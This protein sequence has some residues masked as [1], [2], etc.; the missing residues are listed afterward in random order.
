M[1][2][3]LLE[4]DGAL[5]HEEACESLDAKLGEEALV[6]AMSGQEQ[7]SKILSALSPISNKRERKKNPRFSDYEM[8]EKPENPCPKQKRGGRP[9]RKTS[10]DTETPQPT[11]HCGSKAAEPTDQSPEQQSPQKK[12][13][14]RPPKDKS[15]SQQRNDWDKKAIAPSD[16]GDQ[17]TGSHTS[18]KELSLKSPDI[19]AK[20]KQKTPARKKPDR[21]IK[22]E[23]LSTEAE[24]AFSEQQPVETPK[25]KRKYLKKK[26]VPPQEMAPMLQNDTEET[27]AR[28]DP[29]TNLGGRPRRSAAKTALKYLH[30]LAQESLS[31][32]EASDSRS[33]SPDSLSDRPGPRQGAAAMRC[34][35]R[36]P[37]DCD[38]FEGDE[39]FLPGGGDEEMLDDMED[40]EDEEETEGLES[41]LEP[42]TQYLNKSNILHRRVFGVA[43][44]GIS[45]AMMKPALDAYK[46]NKKFR[47]EHHSDSVFP[48]W[49]PTVNDWTLVSSSELEKYLPR[50]LQ[51]AAFKVSR[52]GLGNKETVQRLN[53]FQVSDPHPERLDLTVFVGGPVWALEWCPLPDGATAHQYLALACHQGMDQQHVFNQMYAGAG[54][55]QLWDM[56]GLD[57]RSRPEAGPASLVYGLGQEKGFVWQLKWCPAGAWE[58]PN[59]SRKA[60]FLQRL[61]LLAVAV[62]T[63]VVSIYSLPHPQALCSPWSSEGDN[64]VPPVYQAREVLTL[65]L[66]ASKA[67]HHDKSGQ[68]LS[69]DWLPEK[70]HNIMAIGFYDGTVGLWDLSSCSSLL[71]VCDPSNGLTL[72]P[73]RC[74]VAHDNAVR[75]LCFCPASSQVMATGGNDRMVKLWDLKRLY[76]PINVQKRNLTTEV[77]WPLAS[78][79]TFHSQE[80]SYASRG[81]TGA[82]YNDLGYRNARSVFITPRTGTVWSLS[83]SDWCN[84]LVTGDGLGE[85]IFAL[86]PDFNCTNPSLRRTVERRFPIYFTDMV[87]YDAEEERGGKGGRGKGEMSPGRL[88]NNNHSEE[89]SASSDEE[90]RSPEERPAEGPSTQTYRE[91]VENYYLHFS[92][93]NL[94]SF[95]N[96]K[97]RAP[98]KRMKQ[99]E[100]KTDLDLDRMPLAALHK[101]R[102]NP[103]M[104]C[105][106]WVASVGQAGLLRVHCL[107]NMSGSHINTQLSALP[108]EPG[109]QEEEE[110]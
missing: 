97:R 24:K 100:V 88:N 16:G 34:K 75:A 91:A 3:P 83:F 30:S 48:E 62:S 54:L 80:I 99:T 90:E 96:Y 76:Q 36:R 25:P 67:P 28:P 58:P 82:Y 27:S 39:D 57:Y 109:G 21:K 59:T 43:T 110:Q 32:P 13:R 84:S 69:M 66:G 93:S 29:E 44:N 49:L 70:P 85:V 101:V 9:P 56:G 52:E 6:A 12:R 15:R 68:V 55:V 2:L 40:E 63:G 98:W 19:T 105:H 106:A 102:F 79:G 74:F 51:S 50:E 45:N 77:C 33:G 23:D 18:S 11:L 64:H 71:R 31:G 107:H 1:E 86:L 47:E 46:A 78:P 41:E 53:R 20:G 95:K 5:G 35:K 10:V 4:K 92:D 38:D 42:A 103:N 61:G 94:Q 108:T 65:K 73:Y 89:D 37:V 60:P 81:L 7:E 87:R 22:V 14:G 17:D 72:L 104:S 8:E 26:K